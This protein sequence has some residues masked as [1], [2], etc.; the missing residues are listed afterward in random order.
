MYYHMTES[1]NQISYR[2][3]NNILTTV[4]SFAHLER[5]IIIKDHNV[6]SSVATGNDTG[7]RGAK[8]NSE[9]FSSL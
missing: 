3:C 5:T 6:K 8:L 1:A 4:N 9:L 7:L 2:W